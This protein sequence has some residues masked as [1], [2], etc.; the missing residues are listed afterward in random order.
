M[1]LY[2]SLLAAFSTYSRIPMPV[3][4]WEKASIGYTMCFF[5]LVGAVQAAALLL[6]WYGGPA[7]GLHGWMLFVAMT[8]LPLFINGGIHLDGF[9]DTTDALSARTTR[10]RRLE[11]LKDSHTGAFAVWKSA[12]YLLWLTAVFSSF[13]GS[14]I[15]LFAP[16]FVLS[17]ICSGLSVVALRPARESSMLRAFHERAYR[18]RTAVVLIGEL[19]FMCVFLYAR[20]GVSCLRVI[21]PV[22]FCGGVYVYTAYKK[23][24]GVTGDLAGWFLQLAEAACATC[25]AWHF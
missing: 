12:L 7:V 15:C 6:L 23:F 3:Y 21:L 16:A 4:D 5:P 17:R 14:D 1:K 19:L 8:A 18:R 10:S 2:H 9:M 22:F 24:G 11:I 13:Q 25:V 20:W